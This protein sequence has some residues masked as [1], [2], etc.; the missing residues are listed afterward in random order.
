[1]A[2][3]VLDVSSMRVLMSIKRL[4]ITPY[5]SEEVVGFD[6]YD[7]RPILGDSTNIE[8]QDNEVNTKEHEFSVSPLLENVT[9]GRFDFNAVCI[10]FQNPILAEMFNWDIDELT[11]SAFAPAQYVE[12]WAAIQ[13]DFRDPSVPSIVIPKL[14][15]NAKAVIGTLKTGSAEGNIGGTAY[16][17]S[18]SVFKNG[19]ETI[20]TAPMFLFPPDADAYNIRSDYGYLLWDDGESGALWDNGDRIIN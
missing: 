11:G 12:R 18:F 15:I 17:Q 9:L 3:K 7:L 13:I 4:L 1:M 10:D 20:G 2:L 14:K 8:Q 6:Q 19:V 16:E 5:I